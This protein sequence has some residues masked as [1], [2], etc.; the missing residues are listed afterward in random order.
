MNKKVLLLVC[1]A[2]L[3]TLI[4]TSTT[5]AL[6]TTQSQ[7][8]VNEFIPG[9][10]ST[11]IFENG[12]KAPDATNVLVPTGKTLLKNIQV[13]NTGGSHGIDGYVR[14]MLVPTFRTSEDSLAG[15][16]SLQPKRN[17]ITVIA[18]NG[19]EVTLQ[20]V[21]GWS[22]NWIYDNGYFYHKSV[23]SPGKSTN[24][25]LEKVIVFDESLWS[26]FYLEVL[27]DA[28]QAEGEVVSDTWGVTIADKLN[29]P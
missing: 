6:L 20:L 4:A 1:T 22:R 13:K 15:N 16:M 11:S 5:L 27:S 2:L 7:A 23:V 3:L 12:E 24:I 17:K 9:V 26:G 8:K 21:S 19:G 14:V 29:K 25:L 28:V 10:I 18:P